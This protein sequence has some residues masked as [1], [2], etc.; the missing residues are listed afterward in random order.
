MTSLQSAQVDSYL[1][2]LSVAHQ[3]Q[4]ATFDQMTVADAVMKGARRSTLSFSHFLP[5]VIT[6]TRDRWH[7]P[8]NRIW[9]TL[10]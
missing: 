5:P 9:H 7:T 2:A 8:V 10:H 1:V 3:G 6:S 4:L